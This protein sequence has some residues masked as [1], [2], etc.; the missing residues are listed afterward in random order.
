MRTKGCTR[1]ERS[2]AA[3]SSPCPFAAAARGGGTTARSEPEMRARAQGSQGLPAAATSLL[4]G[5]VKARECRKLP[6]RDE[7]LMT[8]VLLFQAAEP[9]GGEDGKR[10]HW[11]SALTPV[12]SA[13]L[14]FD[15]DVARISLLLPLLSRRRSTRP[16]GELEDR[17]RTLALTVTLT[18]HFCP[19]SPLTP[20]RCSRCP[21]AP[22]SASALFFSPASPLAPRPSTDDARPDPLSLPPSHSSSSTRSQ[23]TTT[24]SS[25]PASVPLLPPSPVARALA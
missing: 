23:S 3:T 15:R 16:T 24:Y 14:H 9:R 25:C 6:R 22:R 10:G 8:S 11:A 12:Q 20:V 2:S 13:E 19:R 17:K 7:S 1:R 21:V 18:P 4:K 5:G